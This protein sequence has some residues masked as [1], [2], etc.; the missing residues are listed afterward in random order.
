M[1]NVNVARS[2]GHLNNKDAAH[3]PGPIGATSEPVER[4]YVG[5]P[6]SKPDYAAAMKYMNR[7]SPNLQPH[8]YRPEQGAQY[9]GEIVMWFDRH[10]VLRTARN[11]AVLIDFDSV[12]NGAAIL[13]DLDAKRKDEGTRLKVSFTGSKGVAEQ[14]TWN[15]MRA[16]QVQKQMLDWADSNLTNAKARASFKKNVQASI[17]DIILQHPSKPSRENLQAQ[18]HEPTISRSGPQL[19]R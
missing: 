16:E 1:D 5:R 19:G 17:N 12:E 10:L 2:D 9:G 8:I 14:V 3:R 18:R 13:A 4:Q 7:L 15:Q 11:K 6:L